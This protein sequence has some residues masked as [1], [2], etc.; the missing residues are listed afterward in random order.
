[1]DS[2]VTKLFERLNRWVEAGALRALDLA[3]ARFIRDQGPENDP[4]VLLAVALTSER[5]G[6]GHVCL[7]LQGALAHPDRLLTRWS[8]ETASGAGSELMEALSGLSLA[9]WVGR[10]ARSPAVSDRRGDLAAVTLHREAST[11]DAAPLVLGGT[12]ERPLLYLRRYW[13]YE[14]RIRE[15]IQV[16]LRQPVALPEAA[17]RDLLRL[18]F[19]EETAGADPW[20]KIA[21]ALAARSAFAIITGGP[22]T[23]KTTTVVRLLALLQGLSMGQGGPALRI[24]LAAPTGK[25]AARLNE[26]IAGRVASLPFERLPEGERMRP[27]IPTEASTLHRLLGPIPDSRHFRH[28]AGNPLPADI[29]VVDEASM[30]DVEMMAA[31]LD[32]LRPDA[33]LILLGD[34]DQLASV[35]AGAVL[36]DLCQRA[37]AAHYS[38]ETGDWLRRVTGARIDADY[39]DP[40][41]RPLDQAIAMLRHSYRF[42]AEGGIGALAELVNEG[43]LDGQGEMDRFGAM[44]KLFERKTRKADRSLGVIR[45]IQLRGERDPALDRLVLE[46][47]SGYLERMRDDYPGDLA[48]PAALDA[49]ARAVIQAQGGFQLLTPLRRGAWGV[50]GLNRRILEVLSRGPSAPLGAVGERHWFPGRPVL[51]TRNDQALKLMNGDIGITLAL[52]VRRADGCVERLLRVAFPAGDGADSIRWI[53]PSRL[54]AVE[55]VFA[56]TVHKSQGSEF[57]HTALILPDARNPV[58]TR[59]LIYTG[60]TRSKEVFSLLFSREEVVREA[61]DQRVE[62]ISGLSIGSI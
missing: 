35:E 13:R 23:G 8:E 27:E 49:W 32:A 48:E 41:G 54:P 9:D 30:V 1:M 45:K 60:I 31:L 10:L 51:V 16:R 7:D 57:T 34:K 24:R 6:H 18:L 28:H 59:E 50:E 26:S 55:T 56:M 33:R 62:R 15:G 37:R 53:L 29:L 25:A 39:L 46:G 40:H 44:L 19:D 52:P 21:C 22:G 38:A 43:V 3:L 42:K 5:N 36:G 11:G 14:T 20:Q 17:M 61:L 4:A 2:E 58:L 12:S 47:Y